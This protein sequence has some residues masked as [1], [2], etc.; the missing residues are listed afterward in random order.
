MECIKLSLYTQYKVSKG[1]AD[2]FKTF[3]QQNSKYSLFHNYII[4]EHKEFLHI[5][6]LKGSS[7][8]K[9]NQIILHKAE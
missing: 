3:N 5:S 6:V 9:N 2:E 1:T 7:S 4:L 8:G